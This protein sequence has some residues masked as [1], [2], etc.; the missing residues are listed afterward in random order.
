MMSTGEDNRPP[1][2]RVS[3]RGPGAKIR[4]GAL[5]SVERRFGAPQILCWFL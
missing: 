1:T 3:G 4:C 2:L 5:G